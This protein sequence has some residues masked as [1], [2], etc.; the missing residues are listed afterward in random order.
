MYVK[1]NVIV[2]K[3]ARQT[4][5]AYIYIKLEIL[6]IYMAASSK[7]ILQKFQFKL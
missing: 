2:A 6:E 1:L 7:Q 4:I 5:Q 3:K